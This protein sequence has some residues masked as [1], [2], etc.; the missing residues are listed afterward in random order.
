MSGNAS[1][2]V[3]APV[4]DGKRENV[5]R[6][7]IKF[8]AYVTAKG[9]ADCL[10]LKSGEEIVSKT[11]YDKICVKPD[12]GDG[13]KT[14][15]E[16]RQ[17]ELYEANRRVS[18]YIV[19][20]QNSD[21]GINIFEQTVD[22]DEYPHG[23][24]WKF[25]EKLQKKYKPKT[26]GSVI[27]MENE[28]DAVPYK[29]D[30]EE[31]HDK[32]MSIAGKYQHTKTDEYFIT[33]MA[34]KISDA[35]DSYI[36]LEHLKGSPDFEE[37][38]DKLSA[39]HQIRKGGA[40][41]SKPEKEVQLVA[42]DLAAI[43]CHLCGGKGHKRN[44]CPSKSNNSNNSNNRRNGGGGGANS[45]GGGDSGG[46]NANGKTCNH[47]GDKG[48]LEAQCWKKNPD[49]APKWYKD[50]AAKK[51]AKDDTANVDVQIVNIEMPSGCE[52]DFV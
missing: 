2:S 33:Q 5:S 35:T 38:C 43:I 1:E 32:V 40:K 42:S 28:L 4:W 16:V 24:A 26:A 47:C 49:L 23:L 11:D 14:P 13:A 17:K 37:L 20:G 22:E 46:G 6:Y 30:A 41:K 45:S 7:I 48:H 51:A 44:V 31:Y 10:K 36:V 34:K 25:L 12:T 15:S 39:L 8:K 9:D 3:K 21:N 19:L 50:K 29:G 18:A 52:L 27:E